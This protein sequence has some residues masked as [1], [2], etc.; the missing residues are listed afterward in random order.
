VKRKLL[1]LLP[2]LAAGLVFVYGAAAAELYFNQS[3]YIYHPRPDWGFTPQALDLPFEDV[4]FRS[5]DGTRL[6][7]WYVP[8]KGAARG[9]MLFCHG[10]TG[11]ISNEAGPIGL[12]TD[13]GFDFFLFDYRGFGKSEGAP[14]EKGIAADADAA[15]D[16]LVKV[17]KVDPSR[18]VICGR[19][20]GA[21]V[22]IPL[23]V[24][25][26]P[27]AL[28]VEAAFTSLADIGERLHPFFPVRLLLRA[29]YDSV[30]KLP[31]V[32][33]PVLVA[34]SRED[35]LIPFEFGRKLFAAAPEPKEFLEIT[36]PHNNK[37][38][39]VSQA[40]YRRGVS[41]FLDKVAPRP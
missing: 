24:R 39:F 19:S 27:K 1:R 33:C 21:A 15:W 30:S 40:T 13:L 18:I 2:V 31:K 32:R 36:G 26:T 12:F 28:I 25:H 20:F 9:V 4:D 34:H 22:A 16:Y 17:R 8:A 29:R 7:G 5:A 6:S 11:N 14:D 10:N 23:A 35:E 41:K 3:A 37:D 38:D